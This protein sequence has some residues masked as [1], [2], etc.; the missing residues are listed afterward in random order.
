VDLLWATRSD[1]DLLPLTDGLV[2]S[3]TAW[4]RMPR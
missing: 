3:L 4:G 1:L 2:E